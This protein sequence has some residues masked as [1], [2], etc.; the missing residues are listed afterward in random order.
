LDFSDSKVFANF[1]SS[2][3]RLLEL[4][5][6]CRM[7]TEGDFHCCVNSTT[8][9]NERKEFLNEADLYLLHIEET[10]RI[11]KLLTLSPVKTPD[12]SSDSKDKR[13]TFQNF[14][15]RAK[16]AYSMGLLPD[17]RKDPNSSEYHT[18]YEEIVGAKKDPS[19][20]MSMNESKRDSTDCLDNRR[21][22]IG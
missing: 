22:S 14:T 18:K 13:V 15:M 19:I 8:D 5:T 20:R 3:S 16:G 9:S 10:A 12:D 6:E 4:Q 11:S 21:S 7:N 17:S 2:A 1:P